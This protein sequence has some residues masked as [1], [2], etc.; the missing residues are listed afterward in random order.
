[1]ARLVRTGEE[2][3]VVGGGLLEAELDLRGIERHRLLAQD[4]LLAAHGCEHLL[5]VNLYKHTAT[6]DPPR[7]IDRSIGGSV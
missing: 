6:D 2:H 7:S 3:D 5:A 4:V 1:M